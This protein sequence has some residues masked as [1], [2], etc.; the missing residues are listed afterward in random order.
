M[1]AK[2]KKNHAAPL[3]IIID[4]IKESHQKQSIPSN[5]T[6]PTDGAKFLHHGATGM[7]TPLLPGEK[8]HDTPHQ[9]DEPQQHVHQINPNRIL[10]AHEARLVGRGVFVDVHA[11]KDAKDCRPEDTADHQNQQSVP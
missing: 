3:I 2:K 6:L 10:H 9:R 11:A 8:R 7:Q 4:I 1:K 5:P